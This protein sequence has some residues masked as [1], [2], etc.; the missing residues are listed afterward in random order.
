M[1]NFLDPPCICVITVIIAAAA[2]AAAAAGG[3]EPD[4]VTSV[5]TKLVSHRNASRQTI[6]TLG[7]ALD[8][9]L[10][11]NQSVNV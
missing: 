7:Y 5:S 1:A 2:D 3:G 11:E 8:F 6:S 9:A 10:R 4:L